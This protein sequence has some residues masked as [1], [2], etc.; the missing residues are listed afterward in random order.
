MSDK[1]QRY[2]ITVRPELTDRQR[3]LI[4]AKRWADEAGDR[5]DSYALDAAEDEIAKAEANLAAHGEEP[6]DDRPITSP[7]LWTEEMG[8]ACFRRILDVGAPRLPGWIG[9]NMVRETLD[10]TRPH[11]W[12]SSPESIASWTLEWLECIPHEVVPYLS[13]MVEGS[14]FVAKGGEHLERRA[15]EGTDRWI[16]GLDQ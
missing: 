8:R 10:G 4:H 7:P 5:R 13:R 15:F 14:G 2:T 16:E 3:A 6:A 12:L 1:V 11:C 9:W